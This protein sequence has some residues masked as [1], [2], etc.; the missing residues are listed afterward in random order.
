MGAVSCLQP[1]ND[2]EIRLAWL[3]NHTEVL[4]KYGVAPQLVAQVEGIY[5][6]ICE[7][8]TCREALRIRLEEKTAE[9]ERQVAVME[10]LYQEIKRVIKR[11]L[12]KAIW[13]DFEIEE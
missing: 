13:K 6:S 5:N 3:Y 8:N 7:L 12:P 10:K 4:R 9:M 11:E 2:T 1:K